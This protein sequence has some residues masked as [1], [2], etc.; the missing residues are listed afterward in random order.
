MNKKTAVIF[1]VVGV[2]VIG[3]L[4]WWVLTRPDSSKPEIV[5]FGYLPIASDASFFVAVEEGFFT[6]Q[7]LQ[8][9]PIKFET[10]NQ[11]LEALITGRIDAT[12][13]VALEAALALEANTPGQFRIIEMTAATEDTKVHRIMVKPDSPIQTLADLKGKK[14][15][16]F[17]GSQMVVF[18]KLI[19]GRYFDAESEL[20]IIQLKPPLQ[21]QALEAGQVDALFCLEPTGTQLEVRGLGRAIS[22]NP[23]YEFILKP[24]PTAVGVVSAS[25]A[26]EK[27]DIVSK[28]VAA[29]SLAHNYLRNQPEKASLALVKYTPIEA[30]LAPRVGLYNY[31][32]LNSIDRDA[33]QKLADL[34]VEKGIIPKRVTVAP[35]YADLKR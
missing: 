11:I 17:P 29:L 2:V 7:G 28:I 35:L 20:D 21:P 9:E 23:L 18:L 14:V 6:K 27:P 33:V 5:K 25:L 26:T 12:A 16:T 24:F 8:V 4:I 31:W 32:D 10:S 34:Y 30:D 22:I 1:G 15:G 19:L 3:L 13:I